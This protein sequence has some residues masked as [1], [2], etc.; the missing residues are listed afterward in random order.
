MIRLLALSEAE[1]ALIRELERAFGG[2]ETM[3]TFIRNRPDVS[4]APE[5]VR[6]MISFLRTIARQATELANACDVDLQVVDPLIVADAT[7]S[8]Q[9]S[10]RDNSGCMM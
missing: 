8:S 3:I 6:N 4:I 2:F 7:S 1:K 10:P 5:G 9:D